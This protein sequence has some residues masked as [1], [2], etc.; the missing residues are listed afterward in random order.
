MTATQSFAVDREH[1]EAD[2]DPE[3]KREHGQQSRRAYSVVGA[4][5]K[6][7]RLP[8][9]RYSKVLVLNCLAL[10][11]FGLEAS[12][13]GSVNPVGKTRLAKCPAQAAAVCEAPWPG[14]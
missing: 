14:Q 10:C 8:H 1:G 13:A 5:T 9:V 4:E 12:N 2:R 6:G 3:P 11:F 7:V